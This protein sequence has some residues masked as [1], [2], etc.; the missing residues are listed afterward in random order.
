MRTILG[1]AAL[2]AAIGLVTGA[3]A[4]IIIISGNDEKASDNDA[5][6][7][8][9][10]SPGKDTVSIIDINNRPK[11]RILATLPLINTLVGPPTNVA[12]V[13]A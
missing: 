5:G 12:V 6:Q 3:Q 10:G 11:P 4:Q 1:A 8:I 7:M 9:D 13:C 2:V